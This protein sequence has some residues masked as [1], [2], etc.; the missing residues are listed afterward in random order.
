MIERAFVIGLILVLVGWVAGVSYRYGHASGELSALRAQPAQQSPPVPELP[1]PGVQPEQSDRSRLQVQQNNAAILERLYAEQAARNA[2]RAR[3]LQEQSEQLAIQYRQA[4]IA[5]NLMALEQQQALRELQQR[6]TQ[7][8][9]RDRQYTSTPRSGRPLN[10]LSESWESAE[11]GDT[12]YVNLCPPGQR[13]IAATCLP[14]NSIILGQAPIPVQIV[15][16]IQSVRE[17]VVK[18]PR[19]G[20]VHRPDPQPA[21]QPAPNPAW[22]YRTPGLMVPQVGSAPSVPQ[23]LTGQVQRRLR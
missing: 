8:T 14:A 2:Q 4:L 23:T 22:S 11:H 9:E 5:S 1:T 13:L 6:R 16:P 7:L 15:N 21:P 17:V 20:R 10:R 19:M 18:R 12:V 3:D